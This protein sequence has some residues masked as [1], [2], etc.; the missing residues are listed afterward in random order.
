MMRCSDPVPA[1][2]RH[3]RYYYQIETHLVGSTVVQ[4][5][6]ARSPQVIEFMFGTPYE[7]HPLVRG[8]VRDAYPIAVIGAQTF[9]RN[10]LFMQRETTHSPLSFS[11]GVCF[12]ARRDSD[13]CRL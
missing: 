4:P 2:R 3:F 10:E 5:V 9:R 13:R 11:P 6:P 7:V 12:R 1:L 8:G